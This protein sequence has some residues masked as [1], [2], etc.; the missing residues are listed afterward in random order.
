[1]YYIHANA[2]HIGKEISDRPPMTEFKILSRNIKFQ[3]L[4]NPL[5]SNI[6]YAHHSILNLKSAY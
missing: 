1:M 4:E 2:F 6:K 5:I 3:T